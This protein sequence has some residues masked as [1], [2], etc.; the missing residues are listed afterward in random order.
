MKFH[1][2]FFLILYIVFFKNTIKS[3]T[4]TDESATGSLSSD[5]SRVTTQARIEKPKQP[6]LPTLAQET[7]PQQQ[8]QQKEV[9]SG[10]G[11]EQKVES[12]KSGVEVSQS[13]VERAGRSSGTGGSVGTK[14]SPGSQ[15]QGKVAGP[16]LPRLP[17]LP[18]LPQSFEQSRNQQSSP[19]TPKRNGISPTNAKSPESVLPPAQSFTNLNKSTIPHTIPIKSSFLKYY[20]GV[21][22]TGSCG[23]QF[24]LVIVPHLFIYVETKENNIQLEPRFMKLNERI[25]FEKDKSNLKNKCDVNKKQSFKFILYLQHDLI[26]IKWK[27]YEEK[28]DTT[29][30]IDLNVDVKRYKLP[31]LD[32]PVISI[33]I[34]SL[35]QDGET[36]LM[37]SKDYNLE[38]Q[39]PEKCEAIASDC[40]LS[41]N[42]DIEKCLQCTLLVIKADKND[43]CL[44]YVSKNVK[45]RFEEILTKGED[46][47]DSDE[48]DFI[49][50][51]NYILK[52]IYK[53]N[54]TNGK[55]ELLHFKDINNNLKLELINYCNLLK[56]N[57]VSGILTYEKLGNVQD[58]FN[59][60]TKLL[61][62]HKEENNYVLYHKM[63]NEVLCL[64][65]AND[66]MKNKTG[67]V[68]PQLKYSL[69]KFNKN[70]ENYIKENIFEED[71][72]G[73]VDLTK[74]PVD[75]S[76]SSY[77]YADSLYCN[78][79][80][81][82]RLKDHN[83][84]ISKINVEDQK[85]CAL[86]WAFA[87]I[88][89]LETIKCMKGYEPLNA[90]VLYVTNCLKN[91]NNDVCTEGSN[92][93][94]F[95]ETIEEKGFLPT[96]SNYPYD[97]SK[98][99][100]SDCFLSGNVDIEKC[101]QCTLLV[102]K[103]DKNDE[104]LKYVSKNVKDRFEEILT[105]GEDD[106]DSDEYDFIA[107]ANY[108]LKNI[109]KK[110]D[111][112]GKKELLHFKDINNNLK[113]ELINYCN[114]LKDNDVSGILTYEKLGNVQDIFNNLTKLLEEHKEEN[115][116][117]LYH[118]MKNEVLCLKNANDW[119]K[120]KTGLVLPQLKYSLNKFNKNKENYIKEN[121][122]EEDEN[123]IVDLTK[124]PVDTSYS[125][126]NYADS[127]YCNREYCNRLKDHNNCISKINVE[128]QKNCAL[129]WAFASIYHLE[130]IKCMKGYEPLN[131]SVLYVTNCLKNKNKDVCTEGSNPLVFLETIEEKGFLPT[132]SNYPYD[133]SKVGDIC[134]Q[135]QNDWDNVFENTKVL[136]YNN[137][138][139]S[140]GTK[141]YIAYESEA[142][143]KDMHSFVKLV[144]D[145][146][147]NKGS[148]I[149]Y[150]KAENVLGYELNGKKVQNLCGD[151]TPDHVVNIVGYGNYINNKGE[152]KSYWIVRNS[153]GKYWGDD[154]YFKV[155]MYGPPTCEDNFIHTVVVF[156][157][158][159]PVNENFDKKEHDIYKSYLKNSPDFY[160]NI[161][162]K[163]YNFENYVSPISTWS[164]V[165]HNTLYNN[166]LIW[167]Q[168][169]TDPIGEGKLPAS[170]AGHLRG[171][172]KGNS[173]EN[174]GQR[175]NANGAISSNQ[176][177]GGKITKQGESKDDGVALP[178]STDGKPNT[179]SSV[180]DTNDQRSL[181]NPRATSLQPPSVQIP[182]H[183]GTSAPGNSRTPSIVS[184]TAAEKSRKA[185]IF[186]VLKHIKNS[187]IKM[188]LVK[189][190]NSDNIGG[191]HVCS[192]TYAVNPEKQEECVKFCEENWENCKNKPSPGYC[193]AKLKN[194]NECFFC[195][196]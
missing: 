168:E 4:T 79:E 58:I 195:Y 166:N 108:I 151:K 9:G 138:P 172:G 37:E 39:I 57:D 78:R 66:W 176:S 124:F 38:D 157:V 30:R 144:K 167:G 194:T 46:D 152:K 118:K 116:Y 43:E 33:Q 70:K 41:G 141:G 85:N 45:D 97:Q 126:Y 170:E 19:V 32:Q 188:G 133:Q 175:S 72:N 163:N 115:N 53:K 164:E 196:V 107:S 62:E 103:A 136:E 121:I 34:H 69:N 55:K 135:V 26:T 29:T 83:N 49:A 154:G 61:E 100:A 111:T 131:A 10:I 114:L 183:E 192:R 3:E 6:A 182:N 28:P 1:I 189:Y 75:T 137:A 42:V 143:Q 171:E 185:Q 153:W 104:C 122:F 91:K 81:C 158:E 87:S 169:T 161:Y 146:I 113:L 129:S 35:A 7:Q 148:V 110:N 80:Y 120:N 128:D 134:P 132:E 119:M 165:L 67:L 16:Q 74:F 149:A 156:N 15:G 94:V 31:K 186:H 139:F 36:Y 73:I 47:A 65:N 86:S 56:D 14:I 22:I 11:A 27:V 102:I 109:Y 21:K 84:C 93:L 40:F 187:R 8:Q 50:S 52:N 179:S 147:M 18:Q 48:Y 24:Q 125:S 130:T 13:D 23:V 112:N 101:L 173:E 177:T 178:V 191:D 193:L 160:H 17:Q 77:N 60:L 180:V 71:E 59:N 159:V 140:V 82:N 106:A 44:K 181:P 127:L 64:K 68:L 184:P 142:F 117:V 5:G 63:K 25:D 12:A 92:P 90:S 162:Y 54:D 96:E 89:H 155:D 145:E 99:I 190:D 105:K 20:K 98:A 51:A 150:V 2:S 88:Y 76:Y 174:Q 123:G 95:L